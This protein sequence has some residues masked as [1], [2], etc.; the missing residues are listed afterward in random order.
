M[1]RSTT[2][3]AGKA[4]SVRR[5]EDIR[6]VELR[7]SGVPWWQVAVEMGM[8][9]GACKMREKRYW[10]KRV[11]ELDVD[12]REQRRQMVER[13]GRMITQYEELIA[14]TKTPAIVKMNAVEGKRKVEDSRARLLALDEPPAPQQLEIRVGELQ[15]IDAEVAAL[16]T[17]LGVVAAERDEKVPVE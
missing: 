10:Q 9:E 11:S 4:P 17:R 16:A 2:K 6:I 7:L 13:Y 8:T 14:N 15:G 3:R 1:S 5:L 12:K